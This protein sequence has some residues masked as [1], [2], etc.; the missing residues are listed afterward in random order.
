MNTCFTLRRDVAVKVSEEFRSGTATVDVAPYREPL[1]LEHPPAI[2]LLEPLVAEAMRRF[3]WDPVASDAWLAPRLHAVLRLDRFD[4]S[5]QGL[6]RWV[7]IEVVPGYV[8][9]RF[10]GR[11]STSDDAPS[12]PPLK[13]F[14][15]GA[16]DHALG[17]LWWSAELFRDGP[18]YAPV[19]AAFSKQDIA[20]TWLSLDAMHHRAAAQAAIRVLP[21]L[22]SKGINA[23]SKALDHVL[24]TVQLDAV[25][26]SVPPD[27]DA[28][29]RWMGDPVAWD[30]LV[31]DVLVAGPPEAPTD[32]LAVAAVT[33]ILRSVA[34]E[35][36]AETEFDLIAAAA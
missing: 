20:N 8:R 16:R 32:E 1:H 24:T 18:D 5:D 33:R 10:R 35:I 9:W 28:L 19:V 29:D 25:A 3:E 2:E 21:K 7:A 14:V 26:G 34:D 13:R 17:R 6:W 31:S 22:S 11:R 36:R 15:G 30:E 4:A 12:G 27:L 23:V